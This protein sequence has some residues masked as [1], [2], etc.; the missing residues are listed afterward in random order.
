MK[1]QNFL[2][3]T[4]DKTKS[5][6][7]INKTS[8]LLLSV[9]HIAKCLHTGK[10]YIYKVSTDKKNFVYLVKIASI[11]FQLLKSEVLPSRRNKKTPSKYIHFATF[12]LGFKG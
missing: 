9:E 4:S 1:G 5:R 7:T 10:K 8:P 12:L 6:N 3:D 11:K 2:N